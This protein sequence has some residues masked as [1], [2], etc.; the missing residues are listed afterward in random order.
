MTVDDFR[1]SRAPAHLPPATQALAA[2]RRISQHAN[3][4]QVKNPWGLTCAEVD[5]L[6]EMCVHG[7]IVQT[8][9]RLHIAPCTV[10]DHLKAAYRKLGVH[11]M[12]T[13]C[14]KFDRWR[15]GEGKGVPA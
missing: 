2:D 8:A 6:D 10:Q 13:A 3:K 5:V 12:V 4:Q 15:Q 14:V 7:V 11:R 1:N 9:R